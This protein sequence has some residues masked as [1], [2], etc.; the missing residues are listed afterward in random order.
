MTTHSYTVYNY[1]FWRIT[2]VLLYYSHTGI[3][4]PYRTVI[5]KN[6][7]NFDYDNTNMM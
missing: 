1:T 6:D 4:I 7:V 5:I 2:R 3:F